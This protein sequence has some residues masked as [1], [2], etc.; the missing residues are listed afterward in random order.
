MDLDISPLRCYKIVLRPHNSQMSFL[1]VSNLLSWL[2]V[3]ILILFLGSVIYF[4]FMQKHPWHEM[5]DYS[6]VAKRVLAGERAD[7][8]QVPGKFGA[9]IQRCWSAD[10]QKRPKFEEIAKEFSSKDILSSLAAEEKK[11]GTRGSPSSFFFVNSH[12]FPGVSVVVH[13]PYLIITVAHD[14]P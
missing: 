12:V 9:L 4:I 6:Q 1:S 13:F 3:V 11:V 10:P 5:N 14:D 2:S 8:S 7:T